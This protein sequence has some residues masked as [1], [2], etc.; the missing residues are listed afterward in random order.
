MDAAF[1]TAK[2]PTYTT[3]EL[4]AFVAEGRGN[5]AM[6]AEIARRGAVERGDVS[7]MTRAERLRAARAE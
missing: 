6:I 3:A 4:Q 2:Y 5:I 1:A 7:Q